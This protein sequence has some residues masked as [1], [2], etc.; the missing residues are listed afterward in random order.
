MG[1]FSSLSKRFS[2]ISKTV[3]DI[4]QGVT[5]N[6]PAAVSL[7][8]RIARPLVGA[9]NSDKVDSLANK[10]LEVNDALSTSLQTIT[11]TRIMATIPSSYKTSPEML[12]NDVMKKSATTAAKEA[13]KNAL[14]D[15]SDLRTRFVDTTND[16]ADRVMTIM[17]R[18]LSALN[19]DVIRAQI[20]EAKRAILAVSPNAVISSSGKVFANSH[21]QKWI[22]NLLEQDGVTYSLDGTNKWFVISFADLDSAFD[23][24]SDVYNWLGV[25]EVFYSAITTALTTSEK[26]WLVIRSDTSFPTTPVD[27]GSAVELKYI[28]VEGTVG[29]SITQYADFPVSP[30]PRAQNIYIKVARKI[31]TTLEWGDPKGL[32]YVEL[33]GSPKLS[34]V[35]VTSVTY[36]NTSDDFVTLTG[37]ESWGDLL[38]KCK[39]NEHEDPNFSVPA[40]Y[41]SRLGNPAKFGELIC[42]LDQFSEEKIGWTDGTT[43]DTLKSMLATYIRSIRTDLSSASDD[44]IWAMIICVDQYLYDTGLFYGVSKSKMNDVLLLLYDKILAVEELLRVDIEFTTYIASQL[45]FRPSV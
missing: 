4:A 38:G 41:K 21:N 31:S 5:Q 1:F 16:D 35:D 43:T 42:L 26:V 3:I 7:I 9:A 23:L 29:R 10:V 11:A 45:A 15:I 30:I 44:D 39:F 20:N 12:A 6:A 17:E 19:E 14:L 40:L 25:V 2:E 37:S 33:H 36:I 28:D 8:S 13:A 27:P 34:V 32:G 22:L 24:K 18:D